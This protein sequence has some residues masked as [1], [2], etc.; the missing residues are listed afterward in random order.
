MCTYL[1]IFEGGRGDLSSEKEN[2]YK[3]SNYECTRELSHRPVPN[4]FASFLEQFEPVLI[5][6]AFLCAYKKGVHCFYS[7]MRTRFDQCTSKFANF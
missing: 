2:R 1:F 4:L 7:F 5:L 6:I 3:H